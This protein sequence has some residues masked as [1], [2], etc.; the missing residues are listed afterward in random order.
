MISQATID[1]ILDRATIYDVVSEYVTLK[2]AG[3]NYKGLCPFHNDTTPSFYVSPVKNLC[4]CF[5][6]GKGGNPVHFI[7]EMEQLN[8]IDAIKFLG[9]KYGIEVE[10]R[11]L[12]PEEIKVQNERESMFAI[13]EWA[14]NYFHKTLQETE[15]GQAIGLG[16]FRNRGIRED[17]IEKFKLGYCP[18]KFDEMSKEALKQGYKEEFLEKTGLAFKTERGTFCDKYRGRVIFPWFGVSGKITGFGG[19]VLDAR[20]KGVTQKYVNSPDSAIYHKGSEL[21]GIFHAKK[22][23]KQTDRVYMVEGYTDVISMHQCGI[24]NVVANSGTALSRE[25]IRILLRF[26]KN[27]TLLYDGDE[28]GIHAALRGTNML[29]EDGMNVSILLLPDGDDPDSFA[30]KHNATEFKQY[31]EQNQKDFI[32]FKTEV[33]LGKAGNDPQ[34]KTA[35]ID[36]IVGSISVIPE[37]IARSVYTHQCSELLKINESI[38]IREVAKQIKARKAEQEA[39]KRSPQHGDTSD[40]SDSATEGTTNTESQNEVLATTQNA[41]NDI[42]SKANVPTHFLKIEADIISMVIKYGEQQFEVAYE[43][44]E[45]VP[46]T[47]AEYIQQ[48]LDIDDLSFRCHLYQEILNTAVAFVKANQNSLSSNDTVYKHLIASPNIYISKEIADLMLDKYI[49]PE[50]YKTEIEDYATPC[51][52]LMLDYKYIIICDTL[53]TIKKQLGDPTVISN[54]EQCEKLLKMQMQYTSFKRQLAKKLGDRI[55][56]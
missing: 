18:G 3:V 26:T 30:K 27:I 50:R 10:E 16:Y 56:G 12:T 6:C 34:K 32:T 24:E 19:R 47:V 20:T 23:I 35:L 4:K 43:N 21:Y 5:A 53:E 31:I 54:K 40:N 14:S 41:E 15:E 36:D 46:T 51:M 52:R 45:T 37:E 13:N 29:L 38:L 39:Q 33:L 49:I 7:M 22:A 1:K 44:G 9:K 2:K 28:A 8:Y 17:I 11:E 42:Y 48:E 25:Q 55:I